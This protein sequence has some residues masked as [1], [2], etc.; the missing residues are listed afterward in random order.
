MAKDTAILDLSNDET[1]KMLR[2]VIQHSEGLHWVSITRCR[3]QRSLKQNAY[4][5]SVVNPAVARGM[6]EA[7]GE[8]VSPEEAHEYLKAR[9]ISRTLVNHNTGEVQG[10]TVGSSASLD[11]AEFGE[12]LDKVILFAAEFLNVEIPP[13]ST[14]A[15][16]GKEVRDTEPV[17]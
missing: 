4:L 9:F 12:Y 5:W 10:Y 8:T 7:W 2:K 1:K 13:P 6:N 17:T 3:D 11:T 16:T 15:M 14:M